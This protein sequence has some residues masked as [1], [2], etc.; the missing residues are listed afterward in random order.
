[1]GALQVMTEDD[2]MGCNSVACAMILE[3]STTLIIV[4]SDLSH[5]QTCNDLETLVK[6]LSYTIPLLDV[7]GGL[8]M[9]ITGFNNITG[10]YAKFCEKNRFRR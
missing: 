7:M 10:F 9:L 4:K 8:L 6:A 2:G 1:V 5:S 3:M